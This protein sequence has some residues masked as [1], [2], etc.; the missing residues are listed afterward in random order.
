MTGNC[1]LQIAN[2]KLQISE[3][4]ANS[5]RPLDW[6]V[7]KTPTGIRRLFNLQF[8]ICNLQ[9]AISTSVGAVRLSAETKARRAPHGV[10]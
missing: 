8:A 4:E 7:P 5:F 1:K 10:A 6:L 9:F 3:T 2:C